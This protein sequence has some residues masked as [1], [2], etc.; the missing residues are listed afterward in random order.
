[1]CDC[2]VRPLLVAP[3]DLDCSSLLVFVFAVLAFLVFVRFVFVFVEVL[4]LVLV[5]LVIIVDIFIVVGVRSER[6]VAGTIRDALRVARRPCSAELATITLRS[7][8]LWY[9]RIGIMSWVVH[10][11][12][13]SKP[14]A[15]LGVGTSC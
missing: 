2:R 1:M 15:R 14:G 12:G 9:V 5:V 6:R 4:V 3:G 13:H 8:R 7:D 11:T 10:A